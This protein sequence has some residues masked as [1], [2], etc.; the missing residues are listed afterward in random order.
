MY[1][2]LAIKSQPQSLLTEWPEGDADG[3]A[4]SLAEVSTLVLRS[5]EIQIK[6]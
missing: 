5:I 2:A 4:L 6:T 3:E 1:F